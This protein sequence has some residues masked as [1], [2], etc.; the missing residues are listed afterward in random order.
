MPIIRK[1]PDI[2]NLVSRQYQ[3]VKSIIDVFV[4]AQTPV[5]ILRAVE[6]TLRLGLHLDRFLDSIAGQSLP[7]CEFLNTTFDWKCINLASRKQLG[8]AVVAI[9]SFGKN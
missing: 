1:D 8:E 4:R 3:D 6:P 5:H 2:I 7:K 9:E